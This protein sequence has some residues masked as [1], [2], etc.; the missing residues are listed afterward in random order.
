MPTARR[1]RLPYTGSLLDQDPISKNLYITGQINPITQERL[2]M[3]NGRNLSGLGA[4]SQNFDEP[5]WRDVSTGELEREDDVNGSGIFDAAGKATVHTTMGV[6]ADHPSVPGYIARNPPFQ[7]N[8]EVTDASSGGDV[9]EV[10]G[11]GWLGQQPPPAVTIT[12]RDDPYAFTQY[13]RQPVSL[14]QAEA[15]AQQFARLRPVPWQNIA[16]VAVVS[17]PVGGLWRKAMD[18]LGATE[19]PGW[20]TYAFAGLLVGGAAAMMY[21]AVKGW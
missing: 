21:G 7:V 16:N 12:N 8:R 17:R 11:G 9:I 20:G 3:H 13:Q 2:A 19:P 15:A 14:G 18:G 6:F 5:D 4:T 10:P 1:D